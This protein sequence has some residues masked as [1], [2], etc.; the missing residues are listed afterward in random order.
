MNNPIRYFLTNDHRRLEE[1]LNKATENLQDIQMEYY[2]KFRVGL[3][4]HIKMEEK[5]LFP[6]AQ[7]ANK[8]IPLTMAAQ[9]RL[10]HGALTA[11]MTVPPNREVIKVLRYILDKHNEVEETMEGMYEAC[12]QLAKEQTDFIL[13][14]LKETTEV[15]VHPLST[16]SY[17]LDVAKR[18]LERAGYN[19][20]TIAQQ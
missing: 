14:Q 3:L 19:F 18:A 17:I 11:L 4:T 7:K 20:D 5:I 8:G 12:E 16:A 6:A 15:P 9:L 13:Q 10:D 1:L 2:A